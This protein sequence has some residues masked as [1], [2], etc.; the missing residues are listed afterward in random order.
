MK[1]QSFEVVDAFKIIL[2][3]QVYVKNNMLFMYDRKYFLTI[4]ISNMIYNFEENLVIADLVALNR[5][6]FTCPGSYACSSQHT[7]GP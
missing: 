5:I 4:Y 2:M 3:A 1:I 6:L 7:P